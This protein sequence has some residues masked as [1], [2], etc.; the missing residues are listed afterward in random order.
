MAPLLLAVVLGPTLEISMRVSL[1]IANGGFSI[2]VT[3][4]VSGAILAI[5]AAV[6]VARVVW[7]FL[8]RARSTPGRDDAGSATANNAGEPDSSNLVLSERSDQS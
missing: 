6:G 7:F 4:P 1:S 5:C 8:H 2:F 3:R